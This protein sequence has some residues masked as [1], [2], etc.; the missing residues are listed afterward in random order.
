[1]L[2]RISART[3]TVCRTFPPVSDLSHRIPVEEEKPQAQRGLY[4]HPE[5]FGAPLEKSIA[6]AKHPGAIKMM[7]ASAA[8]PS[9]PS[10]H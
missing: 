10:A 5:L 4:L 3:T 2:L 7:R 8:K 6:A 9:D 1:M